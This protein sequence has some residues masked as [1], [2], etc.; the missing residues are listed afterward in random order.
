MS[1]SVVVELELPKDWKR[2]QMPPAL[3]E[4]LQE[5]LDKQEHGVRLKKEE[6][7]EARALVELSEMLTLMK[8]R[9]SRALGR[10][11]A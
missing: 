5:L 9:V 6:R 10:R 7:K 3:H 4:R 11:P 2:F 8:L 1:R